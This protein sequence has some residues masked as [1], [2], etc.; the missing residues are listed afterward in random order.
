MQATLKYRKQHVKI[1]YI[2]CF[3]NTF[4]GKMHLIIHQILAVD[5]YK[6]CTATSCLILVTD[7]TFPSYNLLCFRNNVLDRSLKLIMIIEDKISAT[8]YKLQHDIN[9]EVA[10][11]STGSSCK[12]DKYEYFTGEEILL[13]HQSRMIE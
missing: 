5:L 7:T 4:I 3:S 10:K 6:K 11:I 13:S 2:E 8:V 12:I 9:R 1:N